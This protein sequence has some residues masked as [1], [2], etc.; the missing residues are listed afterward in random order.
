MTKLYASP[1]LPVSTLISSLPSSLSTNFKSFSGKKCRSITCF[2]DTNISVKRLNRRQEGKT[3]ITLEGG[4][5]RNVQLEGE[6]NFISQPRHKYLFH[7]NQKFIFVF[8]KLLR[9]TI[10]W[11]RRILSLPLQT[12][13][14][15]HRP[16]SRVSS[17]ESPLTFY[18]RS[19]RT[20]LNLF[21]RIYTDM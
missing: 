1:S 2:T 8:I 18:V 17:P 15:E 16:S 7:W 13:L 3:R 14:P 19:R 10:F 11:V 12:L 20:F 21:L 5:G 4:E 6:I 9:Q